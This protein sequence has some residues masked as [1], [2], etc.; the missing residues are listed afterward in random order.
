LYILSFKI[1]KRYN[2]FFI[3]IENLHF[4]KNDVNECKCNKKKNF[5]IVNFCKFI[6]I[7]KYNVCSLQNDHKY[8]NIWAQ[9]IVQCMYSIIYININKKISTIE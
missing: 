3:S 7:L 1:L 8:C 4:C 2:V 6:I 9:C 5:L